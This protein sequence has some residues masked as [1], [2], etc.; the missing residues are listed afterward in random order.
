MFELNK[1]KNLVF[2]IFYYQFDF[3]F[4]GLNKWKWTVLKIVFAVVSDWCMFSWKITKT[5][6]LA[7][8]ECFVYDWL[9]ISVGFLS[10]YMDNNFFSL[11]LTTLLCITGTWNLICLLKKESMKNLHSE[12][13]K[14]S[15][16]LTDFSLNEIRFPSPKSSVKNSR[17]KNFKLTQAGPF[18]K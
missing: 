18:N 12:S 10:F 13:Y 3:Q 9:N 11:I 6:C 14:I 7:S 15:W 17:T 5:V 4:F 8:G 1:T 2:P 16:I